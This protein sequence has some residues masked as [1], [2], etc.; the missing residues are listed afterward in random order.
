MHAL[1]VVQPASTIE[2]VCYSPHGFLPALAARGN[3]RWAKPET[4]AGRA[5]VG[6]DLNE[7]AAL[8]RPKV[9]LTLIGGRMFGNR[10]R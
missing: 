6:G 1:S 10:C 7:Q 5:W 9:V 4:L 8:G 2:P 3:T